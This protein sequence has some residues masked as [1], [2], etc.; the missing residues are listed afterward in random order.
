MRQTGFAPGAAETWK[1]VIKSDP[2]KD[3]RTGDVVRALTKLVEL[4]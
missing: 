2:P 1:F 3:I 4:K